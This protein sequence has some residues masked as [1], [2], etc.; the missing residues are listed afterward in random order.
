MKIAAFCEESDSK[1]VL[2]GPASRPFS[3]YEDNL[4]ARIE[5]LFSRLSRERDMNYLSILG[6]ETIDGRSKFFSNGIHVSHA[7]HDETA[8]KLFHKLTEEVPAGKEKSLIL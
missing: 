8:R 4:S 7:G 5:M 1:L 6:Y 3:A 2:V